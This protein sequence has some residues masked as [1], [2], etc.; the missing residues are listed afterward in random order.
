MSAL[1]LSSLRRLRQASLPHVTGEA[2]ES[3]GAVLDAEHAHVADLNTRRLRCVCARCE[4]VHATHG[5]GAQRAVPRRY[6][7]LPPDAITEDDWSA[8]QIP[9]GTAF[10]FH[11][12]MLDSVV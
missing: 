2:C 1:Q 4:V 9:V 12:S 11:N 10:L 3:C 5:D 6:L 7:L 8:F